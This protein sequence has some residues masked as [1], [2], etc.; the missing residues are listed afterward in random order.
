[1]KPA[2]ENS[3]KSNNSDKTGGKTSTSG[4]AVI[5]TAEQRITG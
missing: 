4:A 1:M 2:R 3:S 5:R